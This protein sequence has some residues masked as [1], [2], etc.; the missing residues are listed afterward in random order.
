M[1]HMREAYGLHECEEN[2]LIYVN[3]DL[4]SSLFAKFSAAGGFGGSGNSG[5]SGGSG[6]SL[7]DGD[8]AA[9]V[10]LMEKQNEMP[11][12]YMSDIAK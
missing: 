7:P 5:A 8:L 4:F 1:A 3:D 6:S 10:H 2:E 9:L 12:M 11:I